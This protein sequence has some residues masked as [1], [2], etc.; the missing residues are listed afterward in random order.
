MKAG[1]NAHRIEP[2]SLQAEVLDRLRDEI[3]RGVWKPGVRLQERLLCER[4]GI[5]RSPLREAYQVLAAEGLLHLLRNRG[6]V[7]S[8]PSYDETMDAFTLVA[9]LET[10]GIELAC[11]KASDDELEAIEELHRREAAAAKRR[12]EAKAF[13]LNNQLHRAIVEASHNRPLMDAHLI[14]SRQ[15]IRVQNATGTLQPHMPSDEH[16]GFIEPLLKRSKAAAV[17]GLRSHLARVRENIAHRIEALA[18]APDKTA[19]A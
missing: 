10:L 13:Q 15:I 16:V 11:A 5:S 3:I 8:T 2:R 4:F 19:K 12:D 6:A 17:K 7:V 1:D 18:S 14:V 9:T